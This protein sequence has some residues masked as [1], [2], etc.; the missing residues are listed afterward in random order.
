MGNQTSQTT[1]DKDDDRA[2]RPSQS[3]QQRDKNS[4]EERR[5]NVRIPETDEEELPEGEDVPVNN[6]SG[7]KL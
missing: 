5:R 7:S 4:E 3:Q 1:Q 2:G 6:R